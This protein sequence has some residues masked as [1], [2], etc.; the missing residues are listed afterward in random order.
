MPNTPG[1]SWENGEHN[2]GQSG[3]CEKDCIDIITTSRCLLHV[4]LT[5]LFS[6]EISSQLC[7][8]LH[9]QQN[10]VNKESL[11]LLKKMSGIFPSQ[12]IHERTAF[13]PTQEVSQLPLFQKDNAKMA[14]QEILQEIFNIFSKNLTQSTWDGIS[15][16]RFQ[17]RLY[18]QIQQ[19]EACLKA[20]MEKDLT[21]PE[22]EDLQHTSWRVKQYFQG[23]DAFLKE[24]QYSLCAWEIICMVISRCFVLT[25]K[26]NRSLSN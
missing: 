12:C 26:L 22:S 3:G 15:I 8:L 24:K 10:K 17:N 20:Q 9:F 7:T 14:M 25:D 19:L 6:I 23:I 5:L 21:N 1:K 2:P 4:C 13:K 11:E 16:V 18:Q